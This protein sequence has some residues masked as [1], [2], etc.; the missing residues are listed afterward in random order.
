MNKLEIDSLNAKKSFDLFDYKKE[1]IINIEEILNNMVKL[2]FDKSHT[3]ILDLVESLGNN[4][5]NYNDFQSTLNELMSQEDEDSG[6]ER[7]YEILIFNPKANAM[8]YD[9]L[10]K[11]ELKLKIL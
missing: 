1:G 8:D 3:E 11:L 7:M 10:K 9:L 2:G 4:K 6:L 5:I